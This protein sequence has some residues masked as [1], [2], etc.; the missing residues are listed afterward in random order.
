MTI[1]QILAKVLE[2]KDALARGDWLVALA[3]ALELA[4]A[5]A[6]KDGNQGALEASEGDDLTEEEVKQLKGCC[7]EVKKACE[8][9]PRGTNTAV[10]GPAAVILLPLLVEGITK[11]IEAWIKKRNK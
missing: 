7:K 8:K 11:L 2:L 4:Q 5:F 1:R 3:I 10:G 6:A 9:P